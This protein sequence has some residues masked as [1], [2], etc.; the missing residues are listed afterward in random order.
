MKVTAIRK[1]ALWSKIYGIGALMLMIVSFG[2][3]VSGGRRLEYGGLWLLGIV[4]AAGGA[5]ISESKFRKI[6]LWGAGGTVVAMAP[7]LIL[8][9]VIG[10]NRKVETPEPNPIMI[11]ISVII[12]FLSQVALLSG[13]VGILLDVKPM[14]SSP[15]DNGAGKAAAGATPVDP[16]SLH[17]AADLKRIGRKKRLVW[18]GVIAVGLLLVGG[19]FLLTRRGAKGD[20][21]RRSYAKDQ[22]FAV[23][24]TRE[25][26]R[27]IQGPPTYKLELVWFYGDSQVQ[28]D[29]DGKVAHIWDISKNLK[30]RSEKRP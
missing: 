17:P 5:I 30:I 19:N 18:G 6:V 16:V 22:Y 8:G 12:G 24:S 13:T 9:I 29:S 7:G 28:F 4:L 2:L 26:V 27:R 15:M 20:E 14:A 25:E 10:L 23:G 3:V 21:L 1:Q 11:I